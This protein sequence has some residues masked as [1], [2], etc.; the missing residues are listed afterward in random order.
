MPVFKNC[1]YFSVTS[2]VLNDVNVREGNVVKPSELVLASK[3][4]LN[5][6]TK[7]VKFML[8]PSKLC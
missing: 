3:K 5:L 7:D 2:L 1:T 8:V 4:K 6:K